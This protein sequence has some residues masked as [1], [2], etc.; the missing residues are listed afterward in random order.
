MHGPIRTAVLLLLAL[1]T[2]AIKFIL[3]E[4]EGSSYIARCDGDLKCVSVSA[5]IVS[6]PILG[7]LVLIEIFHDRIVNRAASSSQDIEPKEQF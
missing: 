3:I 2:L 7:V 5:D 6:G 1:S 4:N